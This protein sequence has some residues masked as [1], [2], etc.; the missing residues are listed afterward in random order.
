MHS[1][2]WQCDWRRGPGPGSRFNLNGPCTRAMISKS[3][4]L[5]AL[6]PLAAARAGGRPR[7]TPSCAEAI[8]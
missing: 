1:D 7:T 5:L 6:S 2:W 3:G 8:T 4:L